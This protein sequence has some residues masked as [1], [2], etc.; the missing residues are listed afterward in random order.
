MGEVDTVVEDGRFAED[1]VFRA[2]PVGLFGVFSTI[3]PSEVADSR[4]IRE[5]GDDTLFARTHG[6]TLETENMPHDLHIG[7]VAS[8]FMDGVDLRTVYIFIRIV[9]EQVTIGLNAEFVAQHLLAVGTYPR[10]ELDVLVE[11]IQFLEVSG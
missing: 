7:H 6:E 8:Q 2:Y 9:F 11:N 10:Q 3:K 5:M 1:H 4:T